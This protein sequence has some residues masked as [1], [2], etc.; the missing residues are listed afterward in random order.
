MKQW[1]P[2]KGYEGLYDVSDEGDVYSHF[3]K[4]CLK[5]KLNNNGYY[6]VRLSLSGKE[7]N[8]PLHRLIAL[9]F[10]PNPENKPQINHIDGNK[11]N[12]KLENLEWCTNQEN[13]RHARRLGL[14]KSGMFEHL[15]WTNRATG[16]TYTGCVED[17]VREFPEQ[18]LH[19]GNLC[20]VK[21][22]RYS[23]HKG[24][25]LIG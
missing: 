1:K 7:K 9:H 20:W 8:I 16:V 12:N 18:K 15:V 23:Q 19:T 21:Q 2:I 24:W 11:L 14:D 13:S 10:I 3:Y 6:T 17:L 22:G 5:L 25:Q 4:V